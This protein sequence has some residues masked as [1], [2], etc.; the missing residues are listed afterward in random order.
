MGKAHLVLKFYYIFTQLNIILFCN[1]NTLINMIRLL[2]IN[3]VYFKNIYILVI[4]NY[5]HTLIVIGFSS[6]RGNWFPCE[7]VESF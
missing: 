7:E 6:T 2:L 4:N 5:K 1:K 3:D